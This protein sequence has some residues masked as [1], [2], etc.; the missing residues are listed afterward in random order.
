MGENKGIVKV[1]VGVMVRNSKGEVLMGL[2]SKLAKNEKGKWTFPGGELEFGETLEQCAA[3]E[4]MEEYNIKVKPTKLLKVID[5]ILPEEGQHWVNPVFEAE[6]VA[7]TP[8]LMEPHKIEK[9]GW[10]PINALPE[11]I[12]KNLKQLFREIEEGKIKV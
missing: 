7:G 3:R 10:F 5:H 1:G 8:K 11:N 9:M 4:A 12:T 2:R 6:L